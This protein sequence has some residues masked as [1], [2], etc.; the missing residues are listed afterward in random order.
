MIFPNALIY[1]EHI[2]VIIQEKWV[3]KPNYNIQYATEGKERQ[4]PGRRKSADKLHIPNLG[5]KCHHG[6][7]GADKRTTH[8]ADT[9]QQEQRQHP[10]WNSVR[11]F[12][13]D[14]CIT[15]GCPCLPLSDTRSHLPWTTAAEENRT[16]NRNPH[17]FSSYLRKNMVHS[18]CSISHFYIRW[19]SWK[20]IQVLGSF[21]SNMED[22][23]R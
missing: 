20:H 5:K 23:N 9:L 15:A 14:L 4:Q 19:C 21:C 22:V 13:L 7:V 3:L 1:Y 8:M 17:R 12:L 10:L 11:E 2:K 16:Q 18:L 6:A